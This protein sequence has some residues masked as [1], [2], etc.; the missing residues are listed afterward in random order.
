[1]ARSCATAAPPTRT[2]TS[3]ARE[4]EEAIDHALRELTPQE[5]QVLRVHFGLDGDADRTPVKLLPNAHVLGSAM[6][7][8]AL[9]KLR[10][11]ALLAG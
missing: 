4:L 5:Q 8:R 7:A 9:R 6:R 3:P 11:A 1:M 10:L 2:K